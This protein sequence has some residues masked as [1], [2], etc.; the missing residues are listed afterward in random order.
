MDVLM[1]IFKVLTLNEWVHIRLLPTD[2]KKSKRINIKPSQ[3][4]RQQRIPRYIQ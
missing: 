2:R 3:S 1:E 4:V